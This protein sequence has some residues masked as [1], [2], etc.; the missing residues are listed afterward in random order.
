[1]NE[2]DG[3]FFGSS[4]AGHPGKPE[5]GKPKRPGALRRGGAMAGAYAD[6]LITELTREQVAGGQ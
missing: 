6:A 3:S 4:H 5:G 1:M 2:R